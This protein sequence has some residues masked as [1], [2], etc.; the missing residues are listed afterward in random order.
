MLKYIFLFFPIASLSQQAIPKKTN[1]IEVKGVSFREVANSLL[2]AGYTLEKTDSNFQTIKTDFKDGT[3]KNKWMKLRLITR[4]KDS[5]AIITGEW[6]NAMFIGGKLLGVEQTIEN[7]TY[8]IE[9]TSGNP[10]NC[11]IEMN[12]FA[13]SFKKEITY[14][15]K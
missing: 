8:K 11:F 10:K 12:A 15:V 2:D 3:G 5:T 9:Y 14:L 13:I 4:I 1:T 7:S 6:Y